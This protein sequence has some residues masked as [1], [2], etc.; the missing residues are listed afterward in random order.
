MSHLTPRFTDKKSRLIL[1]AR[2]ANSA[3]L[4]EEVSETELR[5][6]KAVVL[7]EDEMPFAEDRR[8]PLSDEDRDFLLS[9]LDAPPKPNADLKK[10]AEEW[11]RRLS[12]SSTLSAPEV[13]QRDVGLKSRARLKVKQTGS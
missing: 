11:R 6:R 12:P 8:P 4:I 5:I 3:V 7:P 1:P 2:F 9:L 13:S 10:A